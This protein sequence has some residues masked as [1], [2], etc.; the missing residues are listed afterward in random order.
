MT[1]D[2]FTAETDTGT[3]IE[4][5]FDPDTQG[6]AISVIHGALVDDTWTLT[7][8]EARHIASGIVAVIR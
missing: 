7:P 3:E 5:E 8:D 4:V 2:L 1:V 6:V